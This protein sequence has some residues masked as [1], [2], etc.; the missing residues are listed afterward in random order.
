MAR[1][2]GLPSAFDDLFS[3]TAAGELLSQRGLR[4]PFI[5]VAKDGEVTAP[6]RYTRSGGAG[7]AIDDQVADDRVLGLLADGHTVV[8]QGLHRLWPPLVDFAGDLAAELGH[9]VQVNA[10]LTPAGSRGFAAH[11]DVHDVFVLQIAGAK[12]WRIHDPV[13]TDPLP[14]QVWSDR[15]DAVRRRAAEPP[16][17]DTVLV[18]GDALYL[19]RGYLHSAEAQ[20]DVTLHLTVGVHPMTRRLVVD[21]VAA[22][23]D[24]RPELRASLPLGAGGRDLETAVAVTLAELTQGVGDLE[25]DDVVAEVLARGIKG[26]RPAPIDPVAQARVLPGVDTDTVVS[27]RP[28]LRWVVRRTAVDLE[29]V[30]PDRCLRLPTRVHAAVE[31]LLSAGPTRA[32]D[33]PG[34]DAGDAVDLVRRLIREGVVV[35][36]L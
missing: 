6:R 15:A 28:N 9:P 32:R 19:P 26:T 4:T 16:L 2:A 3:L 23:L 24:A 34:L 31:L 11:Y 35:T 14:S 17:I 29:L 27:I 21:A 18:A 7:A 13:L 33:L 22:L 1:A 25:L 20:D 5:R 36:D 10:Y 30:L 8:L 12:H